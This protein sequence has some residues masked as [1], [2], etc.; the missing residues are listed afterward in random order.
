M[1]AAEF[2]S[3]PDMFMTHESC[4][5]YCALCS[6][7]AKKKTTCFMLAL[8][9]APHILLVWLLS[10]EARAHVAA[11]EQPNAPFCRKPTSPLG[12]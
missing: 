11:Q 4:L 10:T 5:Y 7:S 8:S 12:Q 1:T 6:C 3:I 9:P 2:A